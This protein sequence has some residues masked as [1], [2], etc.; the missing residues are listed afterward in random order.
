MG[1]KIDTYKGIGK[2]E[3]CKT[4]R[5]DKKMTKRNMKRR[6]KSRKVGKK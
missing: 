2:Y 6:F 3:R 4:T 5:V 1:R